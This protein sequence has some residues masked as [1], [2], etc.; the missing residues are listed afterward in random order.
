M[1][2]LCTNCNSENLILV[3]TYVTPLVFGKYA[4]KGIILEMDETAELNKQEYVQ[5]PEC[6]QSY[7]Y[8]WTEDGILIETENSNEEDDSDEDDSD[9]FDEDSIED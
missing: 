6:G 2:T 9:E 1:G 7:E 3:T 5:C 4:E 8:T